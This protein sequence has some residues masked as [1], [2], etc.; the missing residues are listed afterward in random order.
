MLRTT[1]GLI[2]HSHYAAQRAREV[3][4]V[5]A[6]IWVAPHGN[7]IDEYPATHLGR[8]E[9]REQL[10][11]RAEGPVFICFGQ[12]RRYKRTPDVIRAF[13]ATAGPR[14]LLVAGRPIDDAMRSELVDAAA[15]DD[16]VRLVLEEIPGED[17]SIYHRA[18]D[19]AV[20]NYGEVFSSGALLLA[21]SMGVPVLAPEDSAARELLRPDAGKLIGRGERLQD[22]LATYRP[23]DASRDAAVANAREFPWTRTASRVLAAYRGKE[24]DYPA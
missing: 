21:L 17:V 16:R 5:R 7:Y 6:P 19:A 10:G 2:V 22:V 8:D 24:P 12:V 18:A 4:G 9:A 3:L 14:Q 11:L 1:D 20:I 15:G 23:E 13:R